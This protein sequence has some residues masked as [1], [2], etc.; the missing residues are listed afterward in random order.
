MTKKDDFSTKKRILIIDDEEDLV[1]I[2]RSVLLDEGYAIATALNGEEGLRQVEKF[3]PHLI[4]LDM[5]MPKMGGIAFYHQI[6]DKQLERPKIPVLVVTARGNLQELFQQLN[7]DGFMTKPFKIDEL[8]REAGLIISKRYDKTPAGRPA[9]FH[10][11]KKVLLVE[12][13]ASAI[14]KIIRAFLDAGYLIVPANT[15]VKAIEL[16]SEQEFHVIF[17]NLNL[18]DLPGDLLACRFKQM[19]RTSDIPIVLY[20]PKGDLLQLTVAMGVCKKIGIKQ[21]IASNDPEQ[22][23]KEC[24]Y[25]LEKN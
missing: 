16:A 1:E 24:S 8:V 5:N 6:Y 21:I 23:L 11:Q 10:G 13:D 7:V 18:D 3:R 2:M 17:V 19:S 15:A 25:A 22:L 14:G 4:V 9:D 20:A 12:K